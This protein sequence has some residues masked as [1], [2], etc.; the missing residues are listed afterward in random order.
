MKLSPQT[1]KVLVIA[2]IIA[3]LFGAITVLASAG[4]GMEGAKAFAISMC[5]IFYGLLSA[6][7]MVLAEK[8]EYKTLGIAS[9]VVST[10]AF[11][12]TVAAILAEITDAGLLKFIVSLFILSLGLAHICL[13]HH[14][15][16]QNKYAQYARM[17]ATI[18]ITLFTFLIIIRVFDSFMVYDSFLY[19]QSTYKIT[20]V[21]FIIDLTAT[22]LVP[23]CNR[24]QVT[25]KVEMNFEEAP[26]ADQPEKQDPGV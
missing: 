22:L 12:L 18:A 17:T 3:G 2:V 1:I 11:I 20:I 4:M 7:P 14:F 13:L 15:N 24:L 25:E 19:N 9:M 21:A 26:P 23:L 5:F 6:A 8:P 10:L 16:L